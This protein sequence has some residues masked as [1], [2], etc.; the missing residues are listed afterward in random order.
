MKKGEEEATVVIAH[1]PILFNHVFSLLI[2]MPHF[3]GIKFH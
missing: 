3:I 1:L 2:S